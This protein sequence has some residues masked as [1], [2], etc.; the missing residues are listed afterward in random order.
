MPTCTISSSNVSAGGRRQIKLG[1]PTDPTT[2]MGPVANRP[3]YEKILGYLQTAREEGAVAACGGEPDERLGGLFV[4][5]TVF[6]GVD[7]QATIVREEVFGPVLAVLSFTDEDEA[8][9]LAQRHRRTD[10]PE[11]CGPRTCTERIGSLPAYEPAPIWINAYRVVAP[12]VPFG[13]V[14]LSGL[15]RENGL[16]AVNEYLENKSVWVELS[17]GTRDPFTLG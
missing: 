4:K 11:R 12:S 14:G 10:W 6:T 5:P 8:V 15:G 1:D 16:D 13:G 17:G 2:E 7:P 9:R 3:Q